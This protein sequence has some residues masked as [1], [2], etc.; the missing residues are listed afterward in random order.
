M[1][2][3]CKGVCFCG[4]VELEVTGSPVATG[5][6]HCEDCRAWSAAPVNAVS[7]WAPDGVRV[8]KGEDKIGTYNKTEHSHRKFC[9]SCG[10]HL[11]TD[12]PGI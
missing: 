4:A 12:H 3:T 7:L 2:D 8:T 1:S 6:C 10:G 11:M 9:T 5:Y